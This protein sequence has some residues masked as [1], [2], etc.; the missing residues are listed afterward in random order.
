MRFLALV[1]IYNH[2]Q[3]LTNNCVA[4]FN[5]QTNQESHMLLLDDRP[6][7]NQFQEIRDCPRVHHVGFESRF[8]SM[9][10]KYDAGVAWAIANDIEFDAI[11]IWDGDDT[12]FPR[13]LE[14]ASK[15]LE[16][17]EWCYPSIMFSTATGRLNTEPTHTTK[18]WSTCTFRR[19]AIEAIGGFGNDKVVGFDQNVVARLKKI[20]GTPGDTGVPTYVYRWSDTGSDHASGYSR[21]AASTCWFGRVPIAKVKGP[22]YPNFDDATLGM[23]SQAKEKF[24]EYLK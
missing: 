12:F 15:V 14:L 5:M 3:D 21:G 20:V 11:S 2:R 19:S 8:P 10:T 23:F 7:R 22:V 13:H 16:T 18:C 9:G 6:P 24:P 1:G 17:H 4:C